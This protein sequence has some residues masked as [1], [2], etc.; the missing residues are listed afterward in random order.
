M[1]RKVDQYIGVNVKERDFIWLFDVGLCSSVLLFVN[2]LIQIGLIMDQELFSLEDDDYGDL[3]I[4]QESSKS[5]EMPL[6]MDKSCDESELF[7]GVEPADFK[8]PC[9]SQVGP[10]R[11]P[12]YS[13]ISD[14]EVFE[15]EKK[16][17][18][19]NR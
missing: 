7:L 5:S 13:D 2:F 12:M 3:F 17:S 14:D 19:Q 18:S 10:I 15:E 16:S 11:N 4:T 1:V 8:S 9:L 6:D